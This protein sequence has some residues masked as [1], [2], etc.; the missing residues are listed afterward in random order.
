MH[1]V[2][3]SVREDVARDRL[4]LR[5]K[6]QAG[7]GLARADLE[8]RVRCLAESID[9][10][11]PVLLGQAAGCRD[12]LVVKRQGEPVLQERADHG[13]CQ[14]TAKLLDRVDHT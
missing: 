9:E 1:G 12:C 3:E 7:A 6:L 14:H 10:R 8:S 11:G 13:A 2:D 5:R 4:H